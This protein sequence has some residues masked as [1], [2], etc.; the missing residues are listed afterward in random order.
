MVFA[1]VLATAPLHG[2]LE[3]VGEAGALLARQTVAC[4]RVVG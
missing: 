3:S 4:I 1:G 2:R